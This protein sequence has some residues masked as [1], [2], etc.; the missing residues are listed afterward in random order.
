MR[1]FLS[2]LSARTLGIAPGARPRASMPFDP[3][4]T[5]TPIAEIVSSDVKGASP[6]PDEALKAA[7]GAPDTHAAE[8]PLRV[9]FDPPPPIVQPAAFASDNKSAPRTKD[10][11]P[12]AGVKPDEIPA[13]TRVQSPAHSTLQPL[14]SQPMQATRRPDSQ[15][16]VPSMLR[17]GRVASDVSPIGESQ[18]SQ[19]L[20]EAEEPQTIRVT[21]GRVEVR[22]VQPAQMAQ[23]TQPTRR[24]QQPVSRMISLDDYLKRGSRG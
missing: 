8:Q 10:P 17:L 7:I 5:D 14:R 2:R 21:I 23:P 16:T 19:Y 4:P 24:P 18:H 20:K 22:A 9:T 13:E 6:R 1:D 11:L 12:S 15:K 3:S